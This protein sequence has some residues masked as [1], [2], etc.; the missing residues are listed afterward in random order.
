MKWYLYMFTMNTEQTNICISAK[1]YKL[2]N[3]GTN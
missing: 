1:V 2:I 3:S